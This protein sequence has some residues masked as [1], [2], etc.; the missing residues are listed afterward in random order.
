MLQKGAQTGAGAEDPWPLTLNTAPIAS[1]WLRH[2]ACIA[3]RPREV[4][5]NSARS[6]DVVSWS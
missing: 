6:H 1:Q 4:N 5:V 2:Q 3:I